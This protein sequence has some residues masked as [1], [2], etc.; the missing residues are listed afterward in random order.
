MH[1]IYLILFGFAVITPSLI[2]REF[3][4][5]PEESVEAIVIFLFG[6]TGYFIYFAKERAVVRHISEK[7][8]LQRERHDMTRDLSD[9]YSYIGEVNRKMELMMSLVLDLPEAA[10]LF[11]KGEKKNVYQ[12]LAK[13]ILLFSK[14]DSFSLRIIDRG[15]KKTEKEIREG[16]DEGCFSMPIETLLASDQ[17][18]REEGG[19]VIARSPK[20]IGPYSAYLVFPKTINRH[21]DR[22]MFE[23]FATEGLLLYFLEKEHFSPAAPRKNHREKKV[24]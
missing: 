19:Y 4:G 16:N 23:A 1:W 20:S 12:S 6:A 8:R 17:I 9:S 2:H 15:R 14:S 5:I 18:F 24:S 22:E 7:L 10:V 21:E 3:S 13:A 11:R